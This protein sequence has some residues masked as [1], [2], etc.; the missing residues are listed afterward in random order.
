M[1]FASSRSTRP[2][3]RDLVAALD[4]DDVPVAQTWRR[5]SSAVERLGL[6]RPSYPHARR[7]IAVE[8]RR[9]AL[10]ARRREILMET[11]HTFGGGRTPSYD[12]SVVRLNEVA[13]ALAGN[14]ACDSETQGFLERGEWWDEPP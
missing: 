10:L 2:R 8:R 3:L 13:R 7:L 11:A 5:V 1:R 12:E 6:P 4:E 9:R 14:E